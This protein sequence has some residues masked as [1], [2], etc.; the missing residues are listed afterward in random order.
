MLKESMVIKMTIIVPDTS[1][2]VDGRLSWLVESGE[3]ES[4][5]LLIPEAALAE[6][7]HMANQGRASGFTGLEELKK[8][9]KMCSEGLVDIEFFGRRPETDELHD[10]D[11]IIRESAPEVNGILVTG[12]KVQASIAKAKGIDVI[13][14]GQTGAL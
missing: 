14:E 4:P 6:I 13:P 8:L 7:E 11:A 10:I 12:D 5:R 2:I 9:R 3:Y 1:I